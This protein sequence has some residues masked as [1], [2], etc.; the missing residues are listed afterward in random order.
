MPTWTDQDRI[1]IFTDNLTDQERQSMDNAL[2]VTIGKMIFGSIEQMRRDIDAHVRAETDNILNWVDKVVAHISDKVGSEAV[3]PLIDMRRIVEGQTRELQSYSTQLAALPQLAGLSAEG[4]NKFKVAEPPLFSGANGKTTLQKW[5]NKISLWC[6]SQGIATDQQKIMTAL[7]WL[8]GA[9][10]KYMQP[11]YNKNTLGQPLGLWSDFVLELQGI[12]GMRDEKAGA[13]K[14][15]EQLFR[16]KSL[17]HNNFIN[18]AK[19]FRTLAQLSELEDSYL[20]EK[21]KEVLPDNLRLAITVQGGNAPH[22]VEHI[23]RPTSCLLQ[24]PE[25]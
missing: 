14:E 7:T 6:N 9:A 1:R 5:L 18:Y 25:P 8:E 19:K 22:K 12:Y 2:G 3:N 10:A 15:I 24:A 4:G 23:L 20:I 17:A 11:W 21:L 13:R 16:N